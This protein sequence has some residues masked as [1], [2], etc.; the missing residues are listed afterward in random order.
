MTLPPALIAW[1]LLV[2]LMTCGA[3]WWDKRQARAGGRR[4]AER[5]LLTL[6]ALG[7]TLGGWLGMRLFRH[8]TRKAPFSMIFFLLVACQAVLLIALDISA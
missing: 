2:N 8:K 1:L 7:G 6:V 4:L 3:F 5:D